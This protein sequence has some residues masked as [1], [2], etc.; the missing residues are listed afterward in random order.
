MRHPHLGRQS[1]ELLHSRRLN[2]NTRLGFSIESVLV[3]NSF[4]MLGIRIGVHRAAEVH[5]FGG[6]GTRRARQIE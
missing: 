1:G 6:S 3:M 2:E 4:R 5:V